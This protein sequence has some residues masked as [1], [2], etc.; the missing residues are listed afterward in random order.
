MATLSDGYMGGFSGKLGTAVG[1]Q[2]KGKWCLRALPKLVRN[3]RTE[4]QQNHRMLFKQEVQLAGHMRR[5]LN[6]GLG[7]EAD[8]C[9]MTAPNLF[10]KLNQQAFSPEVEADGDASVPK[11]A[12]DWERLIISMGPVAPVAFGVP[13]LTAGTTLDIDFESN[14]LHQRADRYDSVYLYVYCP[15]LEQGYLAAPVYRMTR[16]IAVVLPESFAGRALVLYAFVQ[17][18]QGRCSQTIYIY[19]EAPENPEAPEDPE[20]PES[21]EVPGFPEPPDN[22]S[23]TDSMPP[24]NL[25]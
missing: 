6:I 8:N 21:P 18:E 25:K 1:Y 20:H 11:L 12:V 4:A 3:P 9:Q 24:G 13:T 14:P 7:L 5:A 23:P 15:E 17:D 10:V 19:P 16:H 2:W 22:P